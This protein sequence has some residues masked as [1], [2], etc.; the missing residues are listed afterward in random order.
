MRK[1]ETAKLANI[2]PKHSFLSAVLCFCY[3]S[4]NI[5]L[6]GELGCNFHPV[7][8]TATIVTVQVK[9]G[10]CVPRERVVYEAVHYQHAATT[11]HLLGMQ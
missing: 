8:L 6:P 1:P 2:Y 4:E 10:P 7:C 3:L 11:K 5:I 9:N